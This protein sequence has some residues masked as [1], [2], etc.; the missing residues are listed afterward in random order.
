MDF[1]TYDRNMSRYPSDHFH[2]MR[3]LK[4][5]HRQT[6]C[7]SMDL[8]CSLRHNISRRYHSN[9]TVTSTVLE[10]KRSNEI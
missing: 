1:S 2:G 7:C 9:R 10:D 8:L 6:K 5:H 3:K 4:C